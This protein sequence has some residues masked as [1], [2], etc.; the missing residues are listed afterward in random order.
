MKLIIS[1]IKIIV[2]FFSYLFLSIF[3]QKLFGEEPFNNSFSMGLP[4]FYF[5]FYS[6]DCQKLNGSSFGQFIINVIIYIIIVTIY[7]K[8]FRNFFIKENR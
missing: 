4:R 2:G 8:F 7:Y 6:N 1:I 5:E 3:Y